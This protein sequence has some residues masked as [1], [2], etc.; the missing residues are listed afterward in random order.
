MIQVHYLPPSIRPA[1]CDPSLADFM[2]LFRELQGLAQQDQEIYQGL[3]MNAILGIYQLTAKQELLESAADAAVVL[4][5]LCEAMEH[6]ISHF[7]WVNYNRA[8]RTIRRR[9]CTIHVSE[10][11]RTKQ[12]APFSYKFSFTEFVLLV[13]SRPWGD[14][15]PDPMR[16][17][18]QKH[19]MD[20]RSIQ[21]AA[22]SM[23]TDAF[24]ESNS[25]MENTLF[26]LARKS[27]FV[28]VPKDKWGL[29]GIPLQNRV[30]VHAHGL[31]RP[32]VGTTAEFGP[33]LDT[34]GVRATLVWMKCVGDSLELQDPS[35][36]RG[37]IAVCKEYISKSPL[38]SVEFE[39]KA[40]AAQRAGAVGLI[41][42]RAPASESASTWPHYMTGSGWLAQQI[43]IKCVMV[44]PTRL[45]TLV[46]LCHRQVRAQLR[47]RHLE[48]NELKDLVNKH[49][50]KTP[51]QVIDLLQ[52]IWTALGKL[53]PLSVTRDKARLQCWL[54]RQLRMSNSRVV[55][56][57][58]IAALLLK[59]PWA[60]LIPPSLHSELKSIL[61]EA[62]HTRLLKSVA[63]MDLAAAFS[64]SVTVLIDFYGIPRPIVAIPAVFSTHFDIDSHVGT[65]VSMDPLI[66]MPSLNAADLR[67]NY[68]IC[69]R[70]TV[71]YQQKAQLAAAAGAAML[72]VIQ[73]HF[74][75][76]VIM[77]ADQKL[78]LPVVMVNR[79]DGDEMLKICSAASIGG[80]GCV[81][82]H[83]GATLSLLRDVFESAGIVR[84]RRQV[85]LLIEKLCECLSAPLSYFSRSYNSRVT[86]ILKRKSTHSVNA[87]TLSQGLAF[88][89]FAALVCKR[90][91]RSLLPPNLVKTIS[92]L[93]D[94]DND[95]RNQPYDMVCLSVKS[96]ESSPQMIAGVV[97]HSRFSVAFDAS[98]KDGAMVYMDPRDATPVL[99]ND[100]E[101]K[102]K[103]AVT[104]D[105]SI[106][107]VAKAKLATKAGALALV[108][109]YSKGQRPYSGVMWSD[110]IKIPIV[111][112]RA[113]HIGE[114]P[115]DSVASKIRAVSDV[116]LPFVRE[117]FDHLQIQKRKDY[118]QLLGLIIALA[119]KDAD[120][121]SN[122]RARSVLGRHNRRY[123][124][125]ELKG[126]YDFRYFVALMNQQPWRR[127]MPV[128]LQSQAR[129]YLTTA[130]Q[131]ELPDFMVPGERMIDG[132]GRAAIALAHVKGKSLHV[133]YVVGGAREE[134]QFGML[135]PLRFVMMSEADDQF[136]TVLRGAVAVCHVEDEESDLDET[137]QDAT[138]AAEHAGSI[139]LV[140][141][142]SN[143]MSSGTTVNTVLPCAAIYGMDGVDFLGA[144]ETAKAVNKKVFK[145]EQCYGTLRIFTKVNTTIVD[146][147][148]TCM[149][150]VRTLP[151]FV[152]NVDKIRH[153]CGVSGFNSRERHCR[154]VSLLQQ[155]V[156]HQS[157]S[158]GMPLEHF[159]TVLSAKLWCGILPSGLGHQILQ[160]RYEAQQGSSLLG[161]ALGTLTSSL[162]I[163]QSSISTHLV[164]KVL[165]PT[166]GTVQRSI[167][168]PTVGSV[169][170]MS[171]LMLMKSNQSSRQACPR[172]CIS[173]KGMPTAFIGS[174]TSLGGRLTKNAFHPNTRIVIMQPPE[175]GEEI[176]NKVECAGAIVVCK[177]VGVPLL[178]KAKLAQ[179]AGAACLVIID[180]A[181]HMFMNESELADADCLAGATTDLQAYVWELQNRS[182]KIPCAVLSEQDGD[183]ILRHGAQADDCVD[184]LRQ[185]TAQS[186]WKHYT[187]QGKALLEVALQAFETF[188][189]GDSVKQ[190]KAMEMFSM[191][192]R[193]LLSISMPV[194]APKLAKRAAAVLDTAFRAVAEDNMCITFQEYLQVLCMSPWYDYLP[195]G[196]FDLHLH[197]CR[198]THTAALMDCVDRE[199]K[200]VLLAI[201]QSDPVLLKD[202][203]H[204]LF[205]MAD[206][207]N[208]GV[209]HPDEFFE[210]LDLA[211]FELTDTEMK[212]MHASV[213]V[214][215]DG[216]IQYE[217]FI[218]KVPQI[219]TE[220][221]SDSC[222]GPAELL[223]YD[224]LDDYL[225]KLFTLADTSGDGVLQA[226]EVANLVAM[227]GLNLSRKQV[228]RIAQ[229]AD[230][231]G[232]GVLSFDEFIPVAIALLKPRLSVYQCVEVLRH[233]WIWLEVPGPPL[234]DEKHESEA[235][236]HIMDFGFDVLGYPSRLDSHLTLDCAELTDLIHHEP[237]VH[238]LPRAFSRGHV[239]GNFIP[240][241]SE[242]HIHSIRSI[243]SAWNKVCSAEHF[244][245]VLRKILE[246]FGKDPGLLATQ[247]DRLHAIASR[248]IFSLSRNG[249]QTGVT[250]DI[251]ADILGKYPWCAILP[252]PVLSELREHNKVAKNLRMPDFVGELTNV[253]GMLDLSQPDPAIYV[254]VRPGVYSER[255]SSGGVVLLSL[256]GNKKVIVGMPP[257]PGPRFGGR[258]QGRKIDGNIVHMRVS[259]AEETPTNDTG[260]SQ[261]SRTME[262]SNAAALR[263]N[264]AVCTEAEISFSAS[265]KIAV[266]AGAKALIV[267]QND[268]PDKPWPFHMP[269]RSDVKIPCVMVQH[270][271]GQWLQEACLENDE[272]IAGT[273]Q[274]VVALHLRIVKDIFN[275][276]LAL[277]NIKTPERVA[278]IVCEVLLACKKPQ[279]SYQVG[280][281]CRKIS[282][283]LRRHMNRISQRQ[284]ATEGMRLEDIL[285]I[286]NLRPWSHLLPTSLLREMAEYRQAMGTGEVFEW[287]IEFDLSLDLP[288]GLDDAMGMFDAL[289]GAM[290]QAVQ[291]ADPRAESDLPI[292]KLFGE[293]KLLPGTYAKRDRPAGRVCIK[294]EGHDVS[295]VAATAKCGVY[296]HDTTMMT[297]IVTFKHETMREVEIAGEEDLFE[298]KV[299]IVQDDPT[300]S[301]LK[302][303]TALGAVGVLY[304]YEKGSAA[305]DFE[306]QCMDLLTL[307]LVLSRREI[308]AIAQACHFAK[309]APEVHV[310]GVVNL[311][312]AALELFCPICSSSELAKSV[313]K[314]FSL[315]DT[316][317]P[318]SAPAHNSRGN[319]WFRKL[320]TA[321]ADD[322]HIRIGNLIEILLQR[323]LRHFV[324]AHVRRAF[325]EAVAAVVDMTEGVDIIIA[326][327]MSNPP[328]LDRYGIICMSIQKQ[329][330]PVFGTVYPQAGT[331]F[332][333]PARAMQEALRAPLGGTVQSPMDHTI[334]SRLAPM[335]ANDDQIPG[336]GW[337]K[338][339][340]PALCGAIAV[341]ESSH[342]V[343]LGGNIRAAEVVEAQALLIL[344]SSKHPR[345]PAHISKPRLPESIA[346][347]ED[348]PQPVPVAMV[349]EEHACKVRKACKDHTIAEVINL[350]KLSVSALRTIFKACGRIRTANDVSMVLQVFCAAIRHVP[351]LR[352][353]RLH[354]LIRR[355]FRQAR[356]SLHPMSF[357][358]LA[359]LLCCR[360][361]IAA[362]PQKLRAPL[363]RFVELRLERQGIVNK[364]KSFLGGVRTLFQHSA[365]PST[366]LDL[367][368]VQQIFDGFQLS[369]SSHDI[370]SLVELIY[371]SMLRP[372]P[373]T[374]SRVS[375]ARLSALVVRR[376]RRHADTRYDPVKGRWVLDEDT[377]TDLNFTQFVTVLS[378]SPFHQLLTSK[379]QNEVGEY[380][381]DPLAFKAKGI[382]ES[383]ARMPLAQMTLSLIPDF[384]AFDSSDVKTGNAWIHVTGH[385]APVTGILA[386]FGGGLSPDGL[387]TSLVS[388]DPI[389]GSTGPRYTPETFSPLILN[390]PDVRNRVVICARGGISVFAKARLAQ[391][392]GAQ[393]LIVIQNPGEKPV[394]M[395]KDDDTEGNI[396]IPCIMISGEDGHKL[397]SLCA[398]NK[399]VPF[400]AWGVPYYFDDELEKLFNST[401]GPTCSVVGATIFLKKV[402]EVMR[403]SFF[404]QGRFFALNSRRWS[405]LIRR[406]FRRLAPSSEITISTIK[407]LLLT[408]PW[409][410][411][412]PASLQIHLQTWKAAHMMDRVLGRGLLN[413]S[414]DGLGGMMS[415]AEQIV[416][417]IRQNEEAYRILSEEI[418]E[419]KEQALQQS[420]ILKALKTDSPARQAAEQRLTHLKK[421]IAEKEEELERLK[422]TLDMDFSMLEQM[423]QNMQDIMAG[424]GTPDPNEAPMDTKQEMLNMMDAVLPNAV[425]SN[426]RD[427]T[428]FATG[429]AK[430]ER[431]SIEDMQEIFRGRNDVADSATRR[432]NVLL[433]VNTIL[434][435]SEGHGCMYIPTPSHAT[436]AAATIGRVLREH[437]ATGR[438]T[439]EFNDFLRILCMN[440]W[441]GLFRHEMFEQIQE[442]LSLKSSLGGHLLRETA[443]SVPLPSLSNMSGKRRPDETV[444]I[445]Y[446]KAIP[447]PVV[448]V[449]TKFGVLLNPSAKTVFGMK[450]ELIRVQVD[451]TRGV[452]DLADVEDKVAFCTTDDDIVSS[453]CIA[454]KA[455]I[456]QHHGA[457][458]LLVIQGQMPA[459]QSDERAEGE[460]K[461]P[462]FVAPRAEGQKLYSTLKSGYGVAKLRRNT[463]ISIEVMEEM[464]E[465][466][467]PISTPLQLRI[468]VEKVFELAVKPTP[469]RGRTIQRRI[470]ALLCRWLSKQNVHNFSEETGS[471]TKVL[472]VLCLRPWSQMLP[473][474]LVAQMR[475]YD[476]VL[477]QVKSLVSR[478][479]TLITAPV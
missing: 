446:S 136:K 324:V 45:E 284:L 15:W 214:N 434:L 36:L 268:D 137:Y 331:A 466:L 224:T 34:F 4:Q 180:S 363:L 326:D 237:F 443:G 121:L 444:L 257:R 5:S 43:H 426:L 440:P 135:H 475:D 455:C 23:L 260:G 111:Y 67:G 318:F 291:I 212:E 74:E 176:L 127:F 22:T 346:S 133:G 341:C 334:R 457:V 306:H 17:A 192:Y 392:A 174:R 88:E 190:I 287:G 432:M 40:M 359:T 28:P 126:G 37:C 61:S 364:A 129:S 91:W 329:K 250:F 56:F 375:R 299:V 269:I 343:S 108:V 367:I 347:F 428:E 282:A 295:F 161:S 115:A 290:K 427:A 393:A 205:K 262:V 198:Y 151:R 54:W 263:N 18:L 165:E 173:I 423:N 258:H 39:M 433:A 459:G 70:G 335:K 89:D 289:D 281:G 171:D 462:C 211:G 463:G 344:P 402:F 365:T 31:P 21:H 59:R 371:S 114:L 118:T 112:V 309:T 445:F 246:R 275:R 386:F 105:G 332:D 57:E 362:L 96:K 32:I 155:V 142:H 373:F 387:Q 411:L 313:V 448:A 69:K 73:N 447:M 458:A 124:H 228:K 141:V 193:D 439:F 177:S 456:V 307:C 101:L 297:Q 79:K 476:G 399:A 62:L 308:D 413:A 2:R 379:L 207:T 14:L 156:S 385:S 355:K 160:E 338:R 187:R 164:E 429:L 325:E 349:Y 148:H 110:E 430:G 337:T 322:G 235:V 358:E 400:L 113:D 369:G 200:E 298:G 356:I 342:W 350:E 175:G 264:I 461:I 243:F 150:S 168:K 477:M 311:D 99:I 219:L 182:L 128:P 145:D 301:I 82:V 188:A 20:S 361:I 372:L 259:A 452:P 467:S 271:D 26:S 292:R 33:N 119:G 421:L 239:I 179:Q 424:N 122:S 131:T 469:F 255:V 278:L 139:G 418:N 65:F 267:I 414:L 327:Q 336:T 186:A 351:V 465:L 319:V 473:A 35:S 9:L 109:V 241:N 63:D 406:G 410:D 48:V 16:K 77:D 203:V 159:K 266:D 256:S 41:V 125:K 8:V 117:C 468:F 106:S 232:D 404:R 321:N 252:T 72:I 378:E 417:Q 84:S 368:E 97:P 47:R 376:I 391:D 42:I 245:N 146:H 380:L 437:A 201:R 374:T 229:A 441:K 320:F 394:Q 420:A 83:K 238:Y 178:T 464:F 248:Q 213:D 383:V 29:V 60:R 425:S 75:Q 403:L 85:Q 442:Y 53:A 13:L 314:I 104:V 398:K 189:E 58:D 197:A 46:S 90:P 265:S 195:P 274:G 251:F 208:D 220:S 130:S 412:I 416:E 184:D 191:L 261:T 103:Y 10:S 216:V 152:N 472:K 460:V 405:A 68:A 49:R 154:L 419:L 451:G 409:F 217:E 431:L 389:T 6:P 354:A 422:I 285:S 27:G 401:F 366:D 339:N 147:V 277:G 87:F 270:A 315:T 196:R 388:M 396:K 345:L 7:S 397:L 377:Y 279:R 470:D 273:L 453:S 50:A 225:R 78:P 181:V 172:V 38:K 215:H 166:L 370:C 478:G 479:T 247:P 395:T 52:A 276:H 317:V 157:L 199:S 226:S 408:K 64:S 333:D 415:E 302:L 92:K 107:T 234:L 93:V 323:P 283:I 3:D 316:S 352:G 218:S 123:S 11:L 357:P 98:W 436:R 353:E 95:T 348:E 140:F 163:V 132:G 158:V 384:D 209:L 162:D 236:Q 288:V 242:S 435:R 120:I 183:I 185:L 19:V 223:E 144:L 303:A 51:E 194:L 381:R 202:Y 134:L 294:L 143:E 30:Y 86:A 153:L 330:K 304:A 310:R 170:Q 100:N 24:R 340:K 231:N 254:E 80:V 55:G 474:H 390:A 76:P 94:A 280:R 221:R 286:L 81:R 204:Q 222:L 149:P 296:L 227:S 382:F 407:A 240:M 66:G 25:Q 450:K 300:A 12:P 71:S 471:F 44:A 293:V 1:K 438:A 167:L 169:K 272:A 360:P 244:I 449:P 305:A 233:V 102:G 116:G 454:A 249:A 328:K 206:R 210:A 230:R 253:I 312:V 138:K